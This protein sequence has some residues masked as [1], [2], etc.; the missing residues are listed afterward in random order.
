MCATNSFSFSCCNSRFKLPRYKRY[1]SV[2]A[3][4]TAQPN[5]L[6]PS[7]LHA[8]VGKTWRLIFQHPKTIL[9]GYGLLLTFCSFS[10]CSKHFRAPKYV[11][12]NKDTNASPILRNR[13]PVVL[14]AFGF[15]THGSAMT[16]EYRKTT[17]SRR[18]D[19]PTHC[20]NP[21]KSKASI[22]QPTGAPF[23]FLGVLLYTVFLFFRIKILKT[24]RG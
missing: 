4:H 20:D 5:F 19:A 3:F 6:L 17:S 13:A 10:Y 14:P 7:D 23:S 9:S 22:A 24:K 11:N 8:L 2:F 16:A 12:P 1:R 18:H 21:C 15:P